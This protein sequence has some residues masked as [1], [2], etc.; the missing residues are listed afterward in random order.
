MLKNNADKEK[1][2]LK[3][4]IKIVSY[5]VILLSFYYLGTVL[6][7]L[8]LSKIKFE[9]PL[10]SIGL[11]MFFSVIYAVSLLLIA[12]SWKMTLDFFSKKKNEVREIFEIYS[13]TNIAKY[14]PGNVMHYVGRNFLGR[15]LGLSHSQ[16]IYS[17]LI[18]IFF[19]IFAAVLLLLIFVV[20]G[21]I[22]IPFEKLNID[23]TKR[24]I[25]V[26]VLVVALFIVFIHPKIRNKLKAKLLELKSLLEDKIKFSFLLGRITLLYLIFFLISGSLFLFT[27]MFVLN[28]T[29]NR[30]DEIFIHLG[31]LISSWVI[32]YV[33]PGASGG[34]GVREALI[35]LLLSPIYGETVSISAAILNRIICVAGDIFL[36]LAYILRKKK[37]N[38][39]S[40]GYFDEKENET[41]NSNSMLQ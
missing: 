37:R 34:L 18:E 29:I 10:L 24:I 8:D 4:L 23:L 22:D 39:D 6:W 9:E 36:F 16:I 15:K 25:I 14:I 30:F 35:V 26:S 5:C 7:K 32:G 40:K 28:I 3:L 38:N 41:H 20:T 11:I 21:L 31:A 13:K 19:V 2:K 12:S 17:S 27:N 1:N 33:T